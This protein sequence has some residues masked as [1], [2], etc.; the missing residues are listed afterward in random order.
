MNG[1][2]IVKLGGSLWNGDTLRPWLSH[3]AAERAR[4]IVI[5]PGGGPFADT[6]RH[7]QPVLGYGARAAHRMA[8]LGMEQYGLALLDLEPGLVPART[9]ADMEAAPGA[10]VW[11]PALLAAEADV[12]ESWDVTSDTLAAWLAERLGA[13][14]LVLVKSVPLPTETADALALSRIGVIDPV[15]P[16]RMGRL[17]AEVRCVGCDDLPLFATDLR[18]GTPAGTLLLSAERL[19]DTEPEAAWSGTFSS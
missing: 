10:A 9:V 5:V 2:W 18:G 3:L 6:V 12:E 8:I 17:S 15:L 11:L 19:A 4:R 13:D 14:R 7:A 16:N 1:P